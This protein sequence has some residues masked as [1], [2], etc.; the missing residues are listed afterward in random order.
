MGMEHQIRSFRLEPE[1]QSLPV[2]GC[3][4]QQRSGR[5]HGADALVYYDLIQA[6]DK[7]VAL[8]LVFHVIVPMRAKRRGMLSRSRLA[9]ASVHYCYCPPHQWPCVDWT[10]D[11]VQGSDGVA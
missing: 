1:Q 3:D 7:S 2:C 11:A 10:A 9:A 8:C 6:T 4:I 5:C